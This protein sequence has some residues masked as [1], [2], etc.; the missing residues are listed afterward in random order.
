MFYKG[1]ATH[2]GLDYVA[3]WNWNKIVFVEDAGDGLHGHRNAFDSA[4]MLDV[5]R[6]YSDGTELVRILALGRDASATLDSWIGTLGISFQNEGAN[7]ITDI[8]ISGGDPTAYGLLGAKMLQPFHDGW[9][10]FYTQ[11]HGDN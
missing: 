3:S 4:Y 2:T 9:R 6:D 5:N 1:D 10:M 11:Q 8:H 7:E